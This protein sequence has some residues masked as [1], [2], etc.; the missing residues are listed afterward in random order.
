MYM[1]IQF[2]SFD[3]PVVHSQ[4]LQDNLLLNIQSKKID[5]FILIDKEV[6]IE[7]FPVMESFD[8]NSS[9]ETDY[10]IED[11]ELDQLNPAEQKYLSTSLNSMMN[12]TDLIP[13]SNQVKKLN[14]I[15]GYT[16]LHDL[17]PENRTMIWKF[18]YYL[19]TKKKALVSFLRII[20][21][22][23]QKQSAEA[24]KLLDE[25]TKP[26]VEDA[27]LFI[28]RMFTHADPVRKYA[29]KILVEADN[30]IILDVLL[31]LVQCLR[32]E[33]K[34]AKS[35]LSNFLISRSLSN[36]EI[37][38]N[39]NWYLT[40][41]SADPIFSNMYHDLKH[42]LWI[43]MYK[44]PDLKEH[45]DKLSRQEALIGKLLILSKE[46]KQS[47]LKRPAKIEKLQKILTSK[48]EPYNWPGIL[49]SSGNKKI[50]PCALPL[51][52]LPNIS[53]TSLTSL[54]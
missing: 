8:R 9:R 47:N 12:A 5:S 46:L 22:E 53:V 6:N 21:W 30:D 14:T 28:S 23:N 48:V 39:L 20:D 36:F 42:Q 44:S 50:E 33:K 27:L 54:K 3:F 2:L 24:V 37:A 1:N 45:V 19:K 11:L 51:P 16:C 32:Y 15:I 18:R 31:Q 13:T 29:V 49:Y 41:E 35:E 7:G 38:N 52:L 34:G 25:W 17:T 4:F 40:V 43:N 10:Y 26:D